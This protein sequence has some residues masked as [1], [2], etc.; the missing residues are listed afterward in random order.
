[1]SAIDTLRAALFGDPP[2]VSFKPNR[3]GVINAFEEL[4]RILDGII[5]PGLRS[6]GQAVVSADTILSFADHAGKV[7]LIT[8]SGITITLPATGFSDGSI[9][10]LSNVSGG[11]TT[12]AIPG[13]T[14]ASATLGPGQSV[15]LH[16]VGDGFWRSLF[17]NNGLQGVASTLDEL[18]AYNTDFLTVNLIDQL[19]GGLW[20]RSLRSSNIALLA[21]DTL[22]GISIASSFDPTY[23]W[24]RVWNWIDGYPEWFNAVTGG[25]DCLAALRACTA[26]CPI[27][28]L[29][30]ADYYISA[31]WEI[32]TAYRA[33]RGPVNSDGF[34]NGHGA[35]IISVNSAQDVCRVGPVSIPSTSD[36][37]L[38]GMIIEGVSFQHD[39]TRTVPAVGFEKTAVANLRCEYLIDARI[40]NNCAQEFV[41]GFVFHGIIGSHIEGNRA[42]RASR[43]AEG[44]D[45][46]IGFLTTGP[47]PS[48]LGILGNN[49]SVT[50]ERNNCSMVAAVLTIDPSRRIGFW[51]TDDIADQFWEKH[52]ALGCGVK[53][54]GSGE[55]NTGFTNQDCRLV[56]PVVDQ[57]DGVAYDISEIAKNGS[58][59]IY[60]LYSGQPASALYAV[61][62]QNIGG[63][64]IIKGGDMLMTPNNITIGISY[65]NSDGV[66]EI[67]SVIMHD[68]SR[69]IGISN[70][71]H[72]DIK[73]K[74]VCH[75]NTPTVGT[76]AAT[77]LANS[78]IGK[79]AISVVGKTDAYAQG[80][81]TF[82]ALCDKL[83]IDSTLI[84]P[85]C[86]QGGAN[87][88]VVLNASVNANTPGNYTSAG[89]P[90]TSGNGILISGITS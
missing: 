64:V 29:R 84:D 4:Q 31:K 28:R 43:F 80:V 69:P 16:T 9:V 74:V 68:F 48:G 46:A 56:S 36:G 66:L 10:A 88:K 24:L 20:V 35:R 49:A 23:C 7:V 55:T 77:S 75:N 8:A 41:I 51:H 60:D 79:I 6:R 63:A 5:D 90:G 81:V 19:K 42:F 89:A 22:H 15:F 25:P 76:Y 47:A 54:T 3:D 17:A 86:I 85:A 87:N 45:V 18:A 37:C 14:D 78:Q 34:D 67:D 62:L 11:V 83:S 70:S 58:L 57:Y 82:D 73:A 21:A 32:N 1:M 65:E 61:R 39:V 59:R 13:G 72:F 71:K 26:L 40:A 2:S 12:L 30:S 33:I 27:T 50:W 53:I 52:E 38:R 44:N